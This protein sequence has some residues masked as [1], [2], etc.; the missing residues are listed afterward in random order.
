[1]NF[2]CN[3]ISLSNEMKLIYYNHIHSIYFTFKITSEDTLVLCITTDACHCHTSW[4]VPH[5]KTVWSD[6]KKF[7]SPIDCPRSIT[8]WFLPVREIIR[9]C[10]QLQTRPVSDVMPSHHTLCRPMQ[11]K[12]FPLRLNPFNFFQI[13]AQNEHI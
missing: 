13:M 11:H 10:K 5:L 9:V 12:H 6:R 7:L 8:E 1:M 2:S 3:I 4:L